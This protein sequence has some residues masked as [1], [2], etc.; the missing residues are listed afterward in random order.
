VVDVKLFGGSRLSQENQAQ[1]PIAIPC[2][3]STLTLRR[4]IQRRG[5]TPAPHPRADFRR[6]PPLGAAWRRFRLRQGLGGQVAG[7]GK[8]TFHRNVSTGMGG[9]GYRMDG[10]LESPHNPPTGM[11]ALRKGAKNRLTP[12]NAAYFF[13]LGAWKNRTHPRPPREREGRMYFWDRLPPLKRWAIICRPKGLERQCVAQ[14][15]RHEC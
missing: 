13:G 1:L 10:G 2:R 5:E 6:L 11:W 12:R 8:E 14:S 7:G 15:V 9:V 4:A 3:P